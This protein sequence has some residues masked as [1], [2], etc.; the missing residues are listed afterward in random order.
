MLIT[1]TV[2]YESKN[3]VIFYYQNLKLNYKRFY[4]PKEW[5]TKIEKFMEN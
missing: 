1:R 4:D 2:N 3:L 5:M